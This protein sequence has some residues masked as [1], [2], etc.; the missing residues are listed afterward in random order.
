MI[1]GI[2][3]VHGVVRWRRKDLVQWLFQEFRISLDETT[4]GRELKALGFTKLSARPRHYA[5]NELEGELFKKTSQPHWQRSGRNAR[6]ERISKL[7]GRRSQN[8]AKNK[9]TRRWARRGTRPSA[10]HD[11]RTMWAYIFGAICSK[12]G[13][14]A[15]LVLPYCDTEAMQEHLAENSNA[16]D[17]G[18]H[19]VLILDQA[20]WHV[21]PKLK[22]P[23]NITLMFLPPRSPEL[24]P[25]ENLWQFMRDNWLSNRVFKDYDDIVDHCCR[26]WNWLI[27]QPWKIMSIGM[28]DWAHRS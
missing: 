25:V 22:V 1:T 27:D 9:I 8:R 20:G 21:T 13:K 23:D 3:A 26:A 24:N 5:Q 28:R 19:A 18:A 17:P 15:G 6:P 7:V 4:V 11:Q 16:V 14:G 10:P 2:P 12:K